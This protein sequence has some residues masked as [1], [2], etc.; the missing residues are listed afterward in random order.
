MEQIV[1]GM[2]F[3]E[4]AEDSSIGAGLR[5]NIRRIPIFRSIREVDRLKPQPLYKTYEHVL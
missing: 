2:S 1:A 4:S 5:F 3:I